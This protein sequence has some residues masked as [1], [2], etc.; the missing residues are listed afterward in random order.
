MKK[1]GFV[2][3][4]LLAFSFLGCGGSEEEGDTL[5]VEQ[6]N[7]AMSSTSG[8]LLGEVQTAAIEASASGASIKATATCAGGGSASVQGEFNGEQ[9]F[10]LDIGFSKCSDTSVTIDGSLSFDGAASADGVTLSMAGTLSYSGQQ[11][12]A[13]CSI[14]VTM[15]VNASGL[16]ISG[17]ACGQDMSGTLTL[18]TL[19]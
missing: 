17:R 4:A 16:A 10:S 14:D 15:S 6:A 13:T 3:L 9:S 5:S 11:L 7:L 12:Q 2:V 18:P 8:V 1:I 19:L